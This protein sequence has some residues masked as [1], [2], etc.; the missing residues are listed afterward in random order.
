MYTYIEAE[1]LNTESIYEFLLTYHLHC[2]GISTRIRISNAHDVQLSKC[3][4]RNGID[5]TQDQD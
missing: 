4:R 5:M 1:R 3:E 2:A